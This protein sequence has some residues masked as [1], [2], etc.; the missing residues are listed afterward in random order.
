MLHILFVEDSPMF[1]IQHAIK[2]LEEENIVF[3]YE[4]IGSVNNACKYLLNPPTKIDLAIIDLGLPQFDNGSN[5]KELNGLSI[6]EEMLRKN[7][8]IPTIIN[9]STKIPNEEEIMEQYKTKKTLIRHVDFL[10][11]K[12]LNEFIHEL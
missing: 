3:T 8:N 7:I 2:H 12:W 9:S 10:D 5:Y 6:I 11:G 1:K 4:I